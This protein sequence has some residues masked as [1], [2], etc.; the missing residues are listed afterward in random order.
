MAPNPP[1]YMPPA[2]HHLLV[3]TWLGAC[4][5]P[6]LGTTPPSPRWRERAAD[7]RAPGG[8]PRSLPRVEGR[9]ARARR[10]TA[11]FLIALDRGDPLRALRL[12]APRPWRTRTLTRS[13]KRREPL[14]ITALLDAFQP[15]SPALAPSRIDPSRT[16]H[17]PFDPAEPLVSAR[18]Q[19]LGQALRGK[20]PDGLRSS[21]LLVRLPL[22]RGIRIPLVHRGQIRIL[23]R[24]EDPA[25]PILGF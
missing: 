23:V 4:A 19:P 25:A 22:P 21:D 8:D 17:L 15:S 14:T 13:P 2:R 7:L 5:T 12:L 1:R 10:L 20:I 9:A 3:L 16:G 11:E 24:P 6:Y 18:I